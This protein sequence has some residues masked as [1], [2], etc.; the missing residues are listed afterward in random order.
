MTIYQIFTRLYGNPCSNNIKEGSI[1][2]NGCAKLNGFSEA[3]LRR[4][5]SDGYTHVWFTGVIEHATQTDYSPYGIAR[6]HPAIVKGRAGSPY[7]IK[8]YYDIDPDLAVDV[9]KRMPEFD[10]LVKRTHKAGLKMIVDFVPNHVCRQYHS[11]AAPKGVED[12]GAGDNTGLHF[13]TANN[14]YYCWGEPLHTDFAPRRDAA[15][16]PYIEQPA[17]ATGNDHFDAWPSANDWY[18]TVKLNYGVDYCDA[19]GCSTHFDPIPSTWKKMLDILL[20]W[21]AKGVDAFRCDMAEMVPVEFWEWA[22]AR[23]RK[24]YP[25][26]TFIAEVYN[27]ALYRDYI[28]RGGFD[29]L[30]DKVGL[31]DTLRAVVRG[32]APASAITA[33]WQCVDDIRNH[34]LYF[35]ENH[36]EQ[37]I[38][39]TFFC[40]D[41]RKAI[42]AVVAEAFMGTNPLMVYAGQEI[43]ER[44]E[45]AEGFSGHD[46]RTT[47]FDYWSP[48]KLQKLFA[49][50]ADGKV[51]K[52]A[53]TAYG[54][55]AYA[56]KGLV[57]TA[58]EKE[59]YHAYRRIVS[60]RE[61]ESA[62]TAGHFYDLMYVN[63]DNSQKFDSNSHY[64]F[65]R[66]SE[67]QLLLVV[68]NFGDKEAEM[69]VRIPSHAF[70][71]LHIPE[72]SFRVLDLLSGEKGT[73]A[74]HPD[75]FSQVKVPAFG[76]VCYDIRV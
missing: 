52:A 30:Y 18:E 63:L 67:R 26:I 68:C 61:S 55:T 28:F 25:S 13:S 6:N 23:V 66:R 16:Y 62:L 7:A 9:P 19:G 5:K 71:F 48:Q 50:G 29:Y 51:R 41:A 20:F 38:A 10:R 58:E 47:I 73:L 8:D 74:I 70:E 24:A 31:Y 64:A 43:G 1:E 40:G 57:L 53:Q 35:M 27:P 21:G 14:F 34:M 33:K 49:L 17:K 45:D 46:G 12:L 15:E 75:A 11:D 76:A 36:D 22:I 54:H 32:E 44:G 56:G 39:S 42:P 65:L 3:V 4:I 60:L 2:Q 69:G 37:R 72:G 59:L